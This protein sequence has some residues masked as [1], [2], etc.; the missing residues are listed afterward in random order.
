M[1]LFP[2]P[3]TFLVIFG[4]GKMLDEA[5]ALFQLIHYG[6]QIYL[7]RSDFQRN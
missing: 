5:R 3:C 7:L 2:F 6:I 4:L 1:K